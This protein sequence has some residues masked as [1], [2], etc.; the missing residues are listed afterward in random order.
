M[1]SLQN[2][3]I[4]TSCNKG[5][6]FSEFYLKDKEKKRYAKTCKQCDKSKRE[7]RG[8]GTT[9]SI[10]QEDYTPEQEFQMVLD[11][12]SILDTWSEEF[13]HRS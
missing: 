1:P 8:G 11:L 7:L 10:Q 13:Q 12:F 2:F 3:Q 4:C 6:D 9:I 5:K